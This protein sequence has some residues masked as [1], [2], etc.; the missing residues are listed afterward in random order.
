MLIDWFT[1]IAQTVNFLVLVWLMKRYLYQPILAAIDSREARLAGEMQRAVQAQQA[2]QL[3]QETFQQQS[4][5]I[6]QRRA[7]LLESAA[8]DAHTQSQQILDAA[9]QAAEAL[10]IKLE[11]SLHDESAALTQELMNRAQREVFAIARQTLTDLASANLETQIVAA[12]TQRLQHIDSHTQ[13]ELNAAIAA[14]PEN[15]VVASAFALTPEQ[16]TAI[17]TTLQ[18][19]F[20]AAGN[21]QFAKAEGLVCGIELQA[22]GQKLAWSIDE[23]LKGLH[24][25]INARLARETIAKPLPKTGA[26][27]A[28]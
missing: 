13:T 11:T 6:A 2:A 28:S 17:C 12:F 27:D 3:A 21:V 15:V 18:Q 20:A 22:N 9:R 10:R 1:V 23:Y 19:T 24:R 4:Q 5:D 8:A 14:A 26:A 16:Q 25:H 7:A